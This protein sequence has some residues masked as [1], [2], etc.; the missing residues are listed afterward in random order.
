MD[1]LAFQGIGGLEEYAEK[2]KTPAQQRAERGIDPKLTTQKRDAEKKKARAKKKELE[3]I[4]QAAVRKETQAA[5]RALYQSHS[6]AQI[7]TIHVRA[8]V[9]MHKKGAKRKLKESMAQHV[10]AQQALKKQKLAQEQAQHRQK[11][12]PNWCSLF[13]SKTLVLLSRTTIFISK[14]LVL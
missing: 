5:M 2:M 11:W 12:E 3:K 9:G 10:K 14:T 4:S 8:E 1:V 13:T 7:S 6:I